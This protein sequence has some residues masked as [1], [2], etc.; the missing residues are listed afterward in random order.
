MKTAKL[1]LAFAA[2]VFALVAAFLW[3]KSSVVRVKPAVTNSGE[4]ASARIMVSEGQKDSGFIAT[5]RE[6]TR[7]SKWAAVAACISAIFQEIALLLPQ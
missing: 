5:A 2:A 4:F 3:Y 1:L 7:W 6:Q